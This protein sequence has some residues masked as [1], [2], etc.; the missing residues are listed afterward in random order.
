[1]IRI[2]ILT[3]A[4][5]AF[6]MAGCAGPRPSGL[7]QGSAAYAVI[8]P[9][10]D[11]SA[12]PTVRKLHAGDSISVKV[13]R[14]PDFGAD[15]LVLD[16]LGNVQ[17]PVLG[18]VAAAGSTPGE[19]AAQIGARLGE[20]Y[21]RNPRVTVALLGTVAQIVTVEG[22]VGT[23]GVYPLGRNETLLTSLARAGSPTQLAALDEVVVFRTVNGQRMGAVFDLRRIRTG[24]APDP[25]I[26][27]GD[28]VVVGFS[29]LK[30]AYR[31]FLAASPLLGLFT[32]F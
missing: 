1:V 28:V 16:E 23:P 19:L 25:Q 14:E 8:P 31:D 13:F 26:V 2:A 17:L 9:A 5:V 30:G 12:V 3:L 10:S 18:D 21:L 20:R 27:D 11:T 7:P 29:Q 6:A 15:K 22:Q 32:I 4:G 24:S